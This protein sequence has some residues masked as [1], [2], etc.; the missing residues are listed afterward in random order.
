MIGT[1]EVSGSVAH[2]TRPGNLTRLVADRL[3]KNGF[4]VGLPERE[5]DC[6]LSISSQELP[7]TLS[8]S[9]CGFVVWEC[10]PRAAGGLGPATLADLAATLLTGQAGDRPRGQR[11]PAGL[12]F[13]AAVGLDLRARGLKVALNVCEDE[14]CLDAET[15]IVVTSPGT[16]TKAEVRITDSGSFTWQRDY[17]LEAATMS[18]EPEFDWWIA[19][20]AE[21]ADTITAKLTQA[22]A[23]C[24][25]TGQAT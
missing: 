11:E 21:L 4:S 23:Q 13:K 22:I 3:A 17:W 7:G 12:T 15:E 18:W 14:L 6:Q 25:P 16:D 10:G 1:N 20:P 9:D 2:R 24:L 19:S 5:D 8:V